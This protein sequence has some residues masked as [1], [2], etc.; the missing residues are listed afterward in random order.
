MGKLRLGERKHSDLHSD[1]RLILPCPQHI[2]NFTSCVLCTLSPPPPSRTWVA[3]TGVRKGGGGVHFP[4]GPQQSPTALFGTDSHSLTQAGWYVESSSSLSFLA[5]P[6][7]S[8]AQASG[9]PGLASH[10]CTKQPT[11]LSRKPS[12]EGNE[13]LSVPDT[14]ELWPPSWH[15]RTHLV[16][17]HPLCFP[18]VLLPAGLWEAG[19]ATTSIPLAYTGARQTATAH[20][21][22]GMPAGHPGQDSLSGAWPRPPFLLL[23]E[24]SG[25]E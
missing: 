21:L 10:R 23:V 24:R 14:L 3:G 8:C 20:R 12:L 13:Q 5:W 11:V 2:S 4:L 15:T 18:S 16:P 22:P 19:G 6:L 9:A 7:C 17:K 25:Q 1:N